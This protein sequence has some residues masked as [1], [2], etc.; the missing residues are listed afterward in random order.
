M[1]AKN[2]YQSPDS[3]ARD[4]TKMSDFE[5]R[6]YYAQDEIC[7]QAVSWF[8]LFFGS[9]LGTLSLSSL[10]VTLDM[11]NPVLIFMS[12]ITLLA[13]MTYIVL[14]W[15]MRHYDPWSR[16]PASFA[17]FVMMFIIPLGTLTGIICFV[18]LK[19]RSHE[20]IFSQK[21]RTILYSAPHTQLGLS[22]WVSMLTGVVTGLLLALSVY[23][24]RA[25][26]VQLLTNS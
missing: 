25:W 17:A 15:G 12:F 9:L 6:S 4:T 13:S 21:Y 8:Y 23:L 5:L 18:L 16:L 24:H 10:C 11:E 1:E 20:D 26:I 7:V 22:V 19:Q 3:T 2:I 14:G